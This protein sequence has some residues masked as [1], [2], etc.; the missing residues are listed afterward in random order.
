VSNR[1]GDYVFHV[2][3]CSSLPGTEDANPYMNYPPDDL[4]RLLNDCKDKAELLKIRSA[5]KQWE[6][7]YQWPYFPYRKK[8]FMARRVASNI[9]AEQEGPA[10]NID[11]YQDAEVPDGL[12]GIMQDSEMQNVHDQDD[13]VRFDYNRQGERPCVD[14]DFDHGDW[15]EPSE[16]VFEDG[17]VKPRG[18]GV[19]PSDMDLEFPPTGGPIDAWPDMI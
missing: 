10:Q 1:Q 12:E 19:D 13:A 18:D 5:L 4:R 17:T 9:L 6:R 2:P 14:M 15:L 16:R 11:Y 8:I 3:Q 7:L